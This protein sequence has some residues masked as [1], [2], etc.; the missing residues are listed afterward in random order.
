MIIANPSMIK[1]VAALALGETFLNF[2]ILIF[3]FL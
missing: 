1:A 2:F 3:A